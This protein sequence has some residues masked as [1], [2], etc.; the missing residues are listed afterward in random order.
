MRRIRFP[1]LHLPT[2]TSE[3]PVGQVL[4][5]LPS[6]DEHKG[7]EQGPCRHSRLANGVHQEQLVPGGS[8]APDQPDGAGLAELLW[9]VLPGQVHAGPSTSQ[10]GPR[11]VGAPQIQA[12]S[13]ARA[14]VDALVGGYRST[15]TLP[16]RAL[17]CWSK[18]VGLDWKSRMRRESHVRF[19][20]GPRVKFPRATRLVMGFQYEADARQMLADLRERLG[21]FKLSLTEDKT[22]L[23][24]FGKMSSELREKRAQRRCETFSFLGFTHI[25]ARS[26][27]GRFVVKRRTDRKR[28][29]RKLNSLR[30]EM[31]H[32]MHTPVAVQHRW[33]C[34]VIRGHYAYYGLPSNRHRL[35]SFRDEAQRHGSRVL[36]QRSQKGMT[37]HTSRRSSSASPSRLPT[38][39]I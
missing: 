29:T 21:K 8:G 17:A 28:L 34:A 11:R 26:R 24:E 9:P 39:P 23:L 32:R 18:A 33:L 35:A 37:W 5:K 12:V 15:R 7:G 16:L 3:E 25:C 14:S 30:V 1:R 10:R 4:R 2:S 36:S 13:A 6:G 27:Q 38:S 20:E 31:R 22:R 19:R